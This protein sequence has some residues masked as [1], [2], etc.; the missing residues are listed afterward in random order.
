MIYIYVSHDTNIGQL[1]FA[2]AWFKREKMS[3]TERKVFDKGVKQL[4]GLAG[5]MKRFGE[6]GS[7]GEVARPPSAN[8]LKV[9]KRNIVKTIV[10]HPS[11]T[12][13]SKLE[14]EIL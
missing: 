7:R 14:K 5:A 8:P 10:R 9:G 12:P 13:T 4:R 2:D 6:Q 11:A 3:L 1:T